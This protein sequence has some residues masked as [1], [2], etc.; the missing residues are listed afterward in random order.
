MWL[1]TRDMARIGLLMLRNGEWH[2]RQVVSRDW[3]RRISSL[4]TPLNEMNPPNQRSLG[5]GNRWGY[6]YMWWVWDAPNSPGPYQGA[7]AGMGAGGQFI[8]VFPRLD[9]VVAH[10]TDIQQASQY[11]AKE[12][13]RN[14]TATDYDSILR[15]LFA[16]RCPDGR[17]P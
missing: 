11:G 6:G 10:K 2:G 1:S 13:R 9:M 14:V 12:R 5:T 16:A 17:C 4:V 7:Y 3:I 8:T 15:M